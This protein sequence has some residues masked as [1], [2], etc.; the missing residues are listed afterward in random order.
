MRHEFPFHESKTSYGLD[1]LDKWDISEVLMF[2]L[3][4]RETRLIV[5]TLGE[6]F[7][8]I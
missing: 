3:C 2:G 8:R 7:P 1:P 5:G 6:A 4:K